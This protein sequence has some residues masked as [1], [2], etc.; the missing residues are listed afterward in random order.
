METKN[1]EQS[2]YELVNTLQSLMASA[3]AVTHILSNAVQD[4]VKLQSESGMSRFAEDGP[5]VVLP[6]SPDAFVHTLWQVPAVY[7]AQSRR[8]VKT[9]L[10]SFSILTRTQQELLDCA[11]QSLSC[12]VLQTTN[13][14]TRFAGFVASRRLAS[15]TIN[16]ANRRTS[17][18]AVAAPAPAKAGTTA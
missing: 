15:E 12:N 6:L 14:L 4:L 2:E 10:D 13:N 11:A 9:M 7:Q 17:A 5:D 1:Q 16:F 8:M 3:D 18:P